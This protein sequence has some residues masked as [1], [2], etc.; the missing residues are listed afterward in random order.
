MRL[1]KINRNKLVELIADLCIRANLELPSR[2][3]DL[4]ESAMK[5]ERFPLAKEL[6]GQILENATLARESGLPI[7]QDCGMS[8]VFVKVGR[9][10]HLDFDLEDAVNEG[11][12]KGYRDGY[13]RMSMLASPLDRRNTENNTRAII[14]TEMTNGD[15][16]KVI[17]CPK[18]GGSENASKMAMLTPADGREGIINFVV[19]AVKAKGASACPPLTLGVGMGGTMEQCAKLAKLALLTEEPSDAYAD[20]EIEITNACNKLG[21]GVGGF[22]GD[23]TVLETHVLSHSC[24][25][26]TLPVAVN[27]QCHAARHAGGEL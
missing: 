26:A 12:S 15:R 8:V 23:T 5:R 16:V 21:T 19:E 24:H 3:L 22:G 13:L 18:G 17:V 9:N 14:H 20:L 25:I 10:C 2:Q 7:C 6:L 4:L 1:R 11:V 27:I